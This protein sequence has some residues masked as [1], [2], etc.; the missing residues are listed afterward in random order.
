[1]MDRARVADDVPP[2]R[3]FENRSNANT[4]TY[5]AEQVCDKMNAFQSLLNFTRAKLD[6]LT[7]PLITRDNTKYVS[8]RLD[9]N[10]KIVMEPTCQVQVICD[11]GTL[12]EG[13]DCRENT[14]ATAWADAKTC[15]CNNVYLFV[16]QCPLRI[17]GDGRVCSLHA[18][19]RSQDEQCLGRSR[20]DFMSANLDCYKQ[21]SFDGLDCDDRKDHLLRIRKYQKCI[22]SKRWQA[23]IDP[24][25]LMTR[26]VIA[27]F[28]VDCNNRHV[29]TL[30][31][32]TSENCNEMFIIASDALT[33][34]V[35]SV[36]DVSSDKPDDRFDDDTWMKLLPY[37]KSE[38]VK[39][40][41]IQSWNRG[42]RFCR[43][44]I[45]ETGSGKTLSSL[46]LA[47]K[48]VYGR[49]EL[50][51]LSVVICTRYVVNG[52]NMVDQNAALEESIRS[53]KR[54]L[55]GGGND[56]GVVN[57]REGQ[58]TPIT[59]FNVYVDVKENKSTMKIRQY[60]NNQ[61]QAANELRPEYNWPQE[62]V[63]IVDEVHNMLLKHSGRVRI[64]LLEGYAR[65]PGDNAY[66]QRAKHVIML[67]AT[68]RLNQTWDDNNDGI[69]NRQIKGYMTYYQTLAGMHDDNQQFKRNPNNYCFADTVFLTN[70][71]SRKAKTKLLL[72][73][74]TLQLL[75][76]Q[77]ETFRQI[78]LMQDSARNRV[79]D[80]KP[81]IVVYDPE[82][83]LRPDET[84]FTNKYTF[85]DR[86]N[87]D[88]KNDII[89]INSHERISINGADIYIIKPDVSEKKLG[90][91]IQLFG[92][93]S[94]LE[95]YL[96]KQ[97]NTANLNG[98]N[99]GGDDNLIGRARDQNPRRV[100][101]YVKGYNRINNKI[102]AYQKF[103][104]AIGDLYNVENN[105]CNRSYIDTLG[106]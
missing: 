57:E 40:T 10:C 65:S 66:F 42:D 78:Q 79:D 76:S 52:G 24:F 58:K 77:V 64:D 48:L 30:K 83:K 37:Q 6:V 3:T 41:D 15:N 87:A 20:L 55:H 98:L 1:M 91:I 101:I 47:M 70:I 36:Q 102:G 44:L 56:K 94:R 4:G 92:R 13:E 8:K 38:K 29:F 74:P 14:Y 51:G 21:W 86:K 84:N 95:D 22:L 39:L 26:Y 97:L 9:Q 63:V 7:K 2:V 32:V 46:V 28:G 16:T 62:D 17:D 88:H 71:F 53:W 34:I 49:N 12:V 25:K 103:N 96:I 81:N 18:K 31:N 33:N 50:S 59:F 93:V 5:V 82:S 104:D 61:W 11:A 75:P 90:F 69:N 72:K 60:I 73:K 27:N 67:S 100:Q 80:K 35:S 68:P 105:T 106:P 99:A 54:A 45:H 19:M 23:F 43:L 89:F 85:P